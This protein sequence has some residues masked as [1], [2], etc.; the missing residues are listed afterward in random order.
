MLILCF[1]LRL[2]PPCPVS[3]ATQFS[4]GQKFFIKSKA[5]NSTC[6]SWKPAEFTGGRLIPSLEWVI[7]NNVNYLIHWILLCV[8]NKLYLQ[9][10]WSSLDM[11]WRLAV[12]VKKRILMRRTEQA[13]VLKA[14]RHTHDRHILKSPKVLCIVLDLFGLGLPYTVCFMSSCSRNRAAVS[15]FWDLL[16][17]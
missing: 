11:V 12:I 6:V 9:L 17:S 3:H 5:F 4:L 8:L 7:V 1:Q 15:L 16:S 10:I 13:K 14:H 2:P